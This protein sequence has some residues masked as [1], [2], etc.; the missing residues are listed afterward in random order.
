MIKKVWRDS[1]PTMI[2][3]MFY[4]LYG[5]VDGLFIGKST[6]DVGLA[7]VNIG[8]PLVALIMAI[9]VGIGS[10]GSVLISYFRGTGEDRQ[11]REVYG[12][13]IALLALSGMLLMLLWFHYDR[14]LY[15][16]G[17]RGAVY[18]EAKKYIR[19][20]VMGSVIIVLECG[21]LPILRNIGMTMEALGCMMVGVF[22]NISI[23]YYLM[24]IVG[25][26]IQGA[27]FGTV[28]SQL[29]VLLL[30]ILL[31]G[32]NK[33]FG[34]Y[35][36]LKR[37]YIVRIIRAGVTPFGIYIAPSITLIFTNLQCLKYGGD[38][39]VA[40][41]AVVSYI[42]FPVLS[43]LGG[44]G[45]GTQP[46]I[47]YYYGAKKEAELHQIRKIAHGGL[48]ILSLIATMVTLLL[49]NHIA[50]WFGLSVE[51]TSY[52]VVGMRIS[53]LAFLG[54][55]FTKFNGVYLNATMRQKTAVILTYAESLLIN[56]IMLFTL[57]MVGGVLGIW[58]APLMTAVVILGMYKWKESRQEHEFIK[59]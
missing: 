32:K 39:V 50:I 53:G 14:I 49:A 27:A 52:F 19:V 21:M 15:F 46:L 9:G 41:Y 7:A 54:Q 26:G 18:N 31:I 44:V 58:F 29:I 59:H 24:M 28:I 5:V 16:L 40:S 20:L 43:I 45:D 13:T 56:P 4:S 11:A 38:A 57:P 47:S 8:W 36:H 37:S 3:V 34:Y 1:L 30:V 17:A 51:A 25:L 10:G 33:E 35:F 12:S 55:A 6:G 23:N 2:A 22:F 48:I 42:V